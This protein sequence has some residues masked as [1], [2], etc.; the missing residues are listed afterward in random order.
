VV[1]NI[2]LICFISC[3]CMGGEARPKVRWAYLDLRGEINFSQLII[4]IKL[5]SD[6]K[7]PFNLFHLL[8][9]LPLV[10][11]ASLVTFEAQL[12]R[13]RQGVLDETRGDNLT[14]RAVRKDRPTYRCPNR[15]K[16]WGRG[17]TPAPTRGCFVM[18]NM[19]GSL[20]TYVFACHNKNQFVL[21]IVF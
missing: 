9:N 11:D 17:L 5:M 14:C 15:G 12:S 13:H 8:G 19:T 16:S 3:E 4:W 1:I 10:T 21:D 7:H 18:L 2:C 20:S 6:Y